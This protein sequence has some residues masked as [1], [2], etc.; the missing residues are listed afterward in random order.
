VILLVI[1]HCR[2]LRDRLILLLP[3]FVTGC[4][5]L[6]CFLLSGAALYKWYTSTRTRAGKLDWTQ[7]KV[8]KPSGSGADE[9]ENDLLVPP[10]K[11]DT[12]RDAF[13]RTNFTWLVPFITKIRRDMPVSVS[14]KLKSNFIQFI[15]YYKSLK[16]SKVSLLYV[17]WRILPICIIIK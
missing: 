13:V 6:V 10:P 15:V 5:I 16:F 9:Y 2:H 7:K 1:L 8:Q 3:S 14:I 12:V 11:P 4:L 17:F